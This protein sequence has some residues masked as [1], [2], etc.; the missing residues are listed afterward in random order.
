MFNINKWGTNKLKRINLDQLN[1]V[2]VQPLRE[3]LIRNE[4][5][6]VFDN[7]EEWGNVKA[8]AI[9]LKDPDLEDER[10]LDALDDNLYTILDQGQTPCNSNFLALAYG[11]TYLFQRINAIENAFKALNYGT[12]KTRETGLFV[13]IGCGIGALLVAL[14]NLHENEDFILNY[15]GY[16]I[17]EEVL[18]INQNL[19]NEV[20]PN[21]NVTINGNQ[22]E[23]FGNQDRGDIKHVIMVFSYLFSQ[24]GIEG[25]FNEF[26]AKIDELFNEFNLSRFYLVQIN[27]RPGY[28][29]EYQNFL[30]QLV[31]S[32]KYTIEVMTNTC[33]NV[34][35]NRLSRLSREIDSMS[36]VGDS[37]VHCCVREIKRV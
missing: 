34:N 13:D 29:T 9:Q 14:R 33:V 6:A 12:D 31:D 26:E 32:K 7:Y 18:S 36:S 10:T 5:I 30:N 8:A 15:R 37:N 25:S 19:L 24:N 2:I 3:A 23:S 22:I 1:Q 27:I 20:Y 17:V 4:H 35:N 11:Y 28:Y 21:N 16:D